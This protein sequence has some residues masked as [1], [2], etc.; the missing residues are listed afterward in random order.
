MGN[1]QHIL[2]CSR[3]VNNHKIYL[4]GKVR[5]TFFYNPKIV[6]IFEPQIGAKII[7]LQHG[8]AK[9]FSYEEK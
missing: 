2:V 9:Y 4:A 3:S 6:I 5:Y 1:F 7:I 8:P